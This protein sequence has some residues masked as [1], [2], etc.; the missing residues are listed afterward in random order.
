MDFSD[1]SLASASKYPWQQNTFSTPEQQIDQL[2]RETNDS[3]QNISAA[4]RAAKRR[5][6]ASIRSQIAQMRAAGK[7]EYEIN[8]ALPGLFKQYHEAES[9]FGA[10]NELYT[11]NKILVSSSNQATAKKISQSV[12]D[13]DDLVREPAFDEVIEDV[14]EATAGKIGHVIKHQYGPSASYGFE[15]VTNMMLSHVPEGSK[16]PWRDLFVSA[17][18]HIVIMETLSCFLP[19]RVP[20]YA[21]IT[22]S[23]IVAKGAKS[24][25][26]H[27]ARIE[28][29]LGPALGEHVEY[30]EGPSFSE[31]VAFCQLSLKLAQVPSQVINEVH[32]WMYSAVT[33]TADA[34]GLTEENAKKAFTLLAKYSPELME[35]KMWLNAYE[36][37]QRLRNK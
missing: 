20:A 4:Q 8:K 32:H 14:K 12:V 10:G 6:I 23:H 27:L 26:S 3:S 16:N 9:R 34:I 22:G 13:F 2:E 25:E 30:G 5:G 19:G 28:T 11:A 15:L 24:L 37:I 7:N 33:R 36:D 35:E 31:S 29:N 17:D 21:A 18:T 1:Y